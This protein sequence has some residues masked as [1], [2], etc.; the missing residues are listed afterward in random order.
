MADP[1]QKEPKKRGGKPGR[2]AWVPPNLDMVKALSM[3]G[4]T[5]QKI[6]ETLEISVRT[7]YRK[8]AQLS[9]FRQ[10]IKKGAAEGEAVITGKLFEKAKRETSGQF[11]FI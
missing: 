8:K 7:L 3:Q 10:A 5:D 9:Q 1:E 6:A 2:P 4:L 11:A